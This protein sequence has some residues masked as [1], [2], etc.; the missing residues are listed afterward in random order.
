MSSLQY[1]QS[2]STAPGTVVVAFSYPFTS[3]TN[4]STST[5]ELVQVT[6]T[7]NA[8]QR[9]EPLARNP[10]TSRFEGEIHIVLDNIADQDQ[11]QDESKTRKKILFKFVLDGSSWVTDPDQELERDQAGNLNN[12]LHVDISSPAATG[13]VP[14]AEVPEEDDD[15][16]IR[17]LGGG[18]W[19]TPYFAVNDSVDL[20]EHFTADAEQDEVTTAEDSKTEAQS[21]TLVSDTSVIV[22]SVPEP[23]KDSKTEDEDEDDKIIRE[24]GGGLWG[25]P[26]FQVNDS[27]TLPEH[28]VEAIEAPVASTADDE[29][30]T[31]VA[32]KDITVP[33]NGNIF[34]GEIVKDETS[35]TVGG[36][37]IETVVSTTEDVVI[38]DAN[39]VFLGETINT[40]VQDT[41]SGE[42]QESVTEVIETVETE[43][44]SSSAE[45]PALAEEIAFAPAA[46]VMMSETETTITIQ[47]DDGIEVVEDTIIF[48]EGPEVDSDSLHSLTTATRP[49]QT[50]ESFIVEQ[51]PEVVVVPPATTASSEVLVAGDARPAVDES[52]DPVPSLTN[53]HASSATSGTQPSSLNASMVSLAGDKH[54]GIVL[55]QDQPISLAPSSELPPVLKGDAKPTVDLSAATLTTPAS[56]K[57]S[58]KVPTSPTVA[59]PERATASKQK[60]DKSEKRRS[61]WKKIK[62]VLA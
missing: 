60:K 21:K 57:S 12:V 55:L 51:L 38:E 23:K 15:V 53:S 1:R 62:E 58:D 28:F 27:V 61:F 52:V 46:G 11:G 35:A 26:A 20:P 41:V 44:P 19:G 8:W 45:T 22:E 39:G 48:T 18:M 7:F 43:E 5:P 16:T 24:L 2:T 6:G 36:I 34:K 37:L 4:G 59:S 9:T 29:L 25:T 10:E 49:V 14:P 40:T 56:T 42:L 47:G 31:A 32:D 33:S 50:G 17:R 54:G 30:T 13:S 3:D